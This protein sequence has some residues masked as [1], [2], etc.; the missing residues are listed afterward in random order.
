MRLLPNATWIRKEI[1][2]AEVAQRLGLKGDGRNFDCWREHPL[3][4]RRRSVGVHGVSNTMR[5]FT[6]DAR[7]LSNIDLVMTV[8]G[9]DVGTAIRWF[10]RNFNGIPRVEGRLKS[11]RKSYAHR[12]TRALTLQNLVT[13]P[14]WAA[15]GSAAKI[16]LAAIFARTPA[17]GGE[18][19]CLR[20]TYQNLIEWSGLRSRATIA[21]ALRELRRTGAIQA[22][23]VPT[24]FRT[25]RGFRLREL[26]I[27]VSARAMRAPRDA[28]RTATGYSVQNL[29]SQYA[30]QNLNSRGQDFRESFKDLTVGNALV[31]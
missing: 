5:C 24:N 10:E 16:V 2:V 15:L 11:K 26:F 9:C 1:P 13:S 6:C 7:S 4:K 25:R 31:Q 14:G 12:Q 22:G 3:A 28:Q 21:A 29:N 27:R 23:T 19:G 18:Q 8:K 20:C 30:V 17:A